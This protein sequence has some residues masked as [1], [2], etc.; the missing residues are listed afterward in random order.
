MRI[1]GLRGT[2]VIIIF[3]SKASRQKKS[4]IRNALNNLEKHEKELTTSRQPPDGAQAH[5][6]LGLEYASQGRFDEAIAEYQASIRLET[7]FADSHYNFGIAYASEGQLD[8]A[9]IEF[10][11]A[12]R[13]KPGFRE[14]H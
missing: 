7:D 14:A 5:D 4:Q 11:T 10:Q 1:S 6:L 9:I 13:L 8:R 3:M 2:N 12:L